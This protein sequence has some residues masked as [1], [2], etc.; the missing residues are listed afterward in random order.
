ML[1]SGKRLLM[2]I[3]AKLLMANLCPCQCSLELAFSP[4][5]SEWTLAAANGRS[6]T[7]QLHRF[8]TVL[9][10]FSW[11]CAVWFWSSV[12][13]PKREELYLGAGGHR[14]DGFGRF[15]FVL[16]RIHGP[17]DTE[18]LLSWLE[19]WRSHGLQ[20]N[21]SLKRRRNLFGRVLQTSDLSAQRWFGASD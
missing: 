12:L 10:P 19:R 16:E 14:S 11:E 9:L 20:H 17:A 2:F 3:P 21:H 13:L 15:F 18:P 6:P 8:L 4:S 1:I 5:I 7:F